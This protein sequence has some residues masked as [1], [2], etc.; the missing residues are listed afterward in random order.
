MNIEQ[1]LEQWEPQPQ[2]TGALQAQIWDRMAKEL[3]GLEL[4]TFETDDFLHL[5]NKVS[6]LDSSMNVLDIGC[7]AGGY[8]LALAPYIKNIIGVDVSPKMIEAANNKVGKKIQNNIR[9]HCMD[10]FKADIDKNDWRKK[11]DIVFAHMTPAISDY[12]TFEKMISS[13]R[14]YCF[15]EQPICM[16]NNI[17]DKALE[18]IGIHDIGK[19]D[20]RDF[21]HAF[22]Y[23]WLKGHRPIIQ[24][25]DGYIKTKK[26]VEDATEWC[27]D[28]AKISTE[29]PDDV[30]SVI[31][32][33]LS[34]VAVGN[35]VDETITTTIVTMYWSV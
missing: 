1:L 8:S 35:F 10:W 26:T 31:K 6:P 17:Q 22:E 7:G 11:F 14:K 19:H 5:I 28:R 2:N 12:S 24:Y 18:H 9:F 3:E 34:K 23:L 29:I 30:K 25:K 13:S 32:S 21:L 33:Y 16:K 27:F 4:P 20:D 15:L